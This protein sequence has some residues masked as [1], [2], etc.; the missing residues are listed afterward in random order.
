MAGETPLPSHVANAAARAALGDLVRVFPVTERGRQFLVVHVFQEG[1]VF[2]PAE[3]N[4]AHAF[5]WSDLT[6]L[7]QSVTRVT[8]GNVPKYVRY[9]YLFVCADG[10]QYRADARADILGNEQCGLEDF[11]RIVNPL[12]TAVQLPAMRAALG[13]G[14]PV[15]FGPLAI[16][17]GGIRK[18]RKKLL[19]WAEFEELK[20]TSGQGILMPN[21]DVVVRRRGKRLNWFRWEAAK[22]PNLGALLALTDEVGGRATA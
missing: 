20:I 15:T 16:E 1:S 10:N 9:Q 5:R 6:M 13:R 19:P 11:G 4:Q 21:G 22:I 2:L 18:D 17:P 14:E 3:Q 7:I 8:S 12:V